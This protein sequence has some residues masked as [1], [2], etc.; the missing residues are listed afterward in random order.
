MADVTCLGRIIGGGFPL[1]A[2]GISKDIFQDMVA[3]MNCAD[4]EACF[5]DKMAVPSI[6]LKAGFASLKLLNENFYAK[7]NKMSEA[8]SDGMNKFF[9]ENKIN[10][11]GINAEYLTIIASP[12]AIEMSKGIDYYE[13]DNSQYGN[14]NNNGIIDLAV[15]RIFTITLSDT[16]S[17]IARSLFYNY[18]MDS[19][20]ALS[21]I[22][23]R[24]GGIGNDKDLCIQFARDNYFGK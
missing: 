10:K 14:L 15:G 18:I 17:N 16:S 6:I 5:M 12:N 2:Y 9:I 23:K 13:V 11:L 24:F 8:F 7:L 19:N 4:I 20:D 1:G 22:Y 21:V 3:K